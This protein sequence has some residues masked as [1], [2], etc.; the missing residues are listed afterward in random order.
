[1]KCIALKLDG[2]PCKLPACD[3]SEFCFRHKPP[4]GPL[5]P[6]DATIEQLLARI[7]ALELENRALKEK[8]HKKSVDA[9][10]G[11]AKMLF[12]HA[13]KNR[14]D[15]LST[16]EERLKSANLALTTKDGKVVVPWQ[17]VKECTDLVWKES[18][19]TVKDE[20]RNMAMDGME[21]R[22]MM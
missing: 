22:N 18:P 20:Y 10:E 16:M 7:S 4:E 17:F 13:N 3:G 11:K 15:I 6:R 1:M 8:R 12:Y 2:S 9:V 21:K 5:L 19:E 14:E